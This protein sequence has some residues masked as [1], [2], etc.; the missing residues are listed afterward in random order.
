MTKDFELRDYL[1]VLRR[2]KAPIIVVTFFVV[3]VS[4]A[5]SYVQTP[6]YAATQRHLAANAAEWVGE[7][8][9][10][11]VL[12]SELPVSDPRYGNTPAQGRRLL[13]LLRRRASVGPGGPAVSGL[14]RAFTVTERR[15]LSPRPGRR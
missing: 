12:I 9:G 2:R 13:A 11:G 7:L 3:L 8:A 14:G 1:R 5:A 4:L 15:A 6:V 10:G